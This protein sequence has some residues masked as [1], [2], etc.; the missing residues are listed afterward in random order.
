MRP[1]CDF[2]ARENIELPENAP[3]R[4]ALYGRLLLEWNEKINLTAIKE[5]TEVVIKHFIDSAYLLKY[6]KMPQGATLLDVGSGAGFPGMVVKIMRPDL[7]VTLLDG[8]AKRF[9]F[10]EDLMKNIGLSAEMLHARA[11][12]ASKEATHREQ[13]DFVTARAV[14]ALPTL[15]EYCL[16]FVKVG[17]TFAAM[18]GPALKEELAA[19]ENALALLG[20]EKAAFF[21]YQLPDLS[22]RGIVLTKKISQTPTKYPRPSAKIAKRPL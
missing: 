9:L 16:P 21:A 6:L 7:A 11:E 18:K 12:L 15:A 10:L 5:P 1:F 3:N 8:H 19:A 14:A 2:C 4:L 20:G 17:G 13:Y 22:E